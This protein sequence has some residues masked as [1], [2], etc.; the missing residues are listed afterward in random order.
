MGSPTT[1]DL[2]AKSLANARAGTPPAPEA[3]V[4]PGSMPAAPMMSTPMMSTPTE[5]T[6]TVPSGT[7]AVAPPMPPAPSMPESSPQ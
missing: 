5:P 7:G 3:S 6:A 1:E 2:N 4:P